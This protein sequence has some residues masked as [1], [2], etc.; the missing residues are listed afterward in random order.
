MMVS[1]PGRCTLGTRLL[2]VGRVLPSRYDL[3][4]TTTW[5]ETRP[6]ARTPRSLICA[7]ACLLLAA[8]PAQAEPT[9]V[10]VVRHADK[11][12]E[13]ASDPALSPAGQQ[14]ALALAAALESARITSI[15]TTPYR[16]AR[17]TALPLARRLGLAP[18]VVAP[19]S[20]ESAQSHV[21]DVVALVR[22]QTGQVLVVGHSNTVPAIVQA[23]GGPKLLDLCESSFG[24]AF[25]VAP[26]AA[27]STVLRL[28]YGEPDTTRGDGCL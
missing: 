24:H 14:R 15:I 12:T 20:G 7:L 6:M 13:P 1:G 8:T 9:L 23:L 2:R 18:L 26:K 11:G 10:V 4:S 5:Q 28:R 19:K 3:A 27:D 22:Q 21:A 17:E 25:V 16:R